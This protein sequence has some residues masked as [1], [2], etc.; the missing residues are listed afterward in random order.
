M[1]SH[2]LA[3]YV[4]KEIARCQ[5]QNKTCTLDELL[6]QLDVRR[7]DLRR[8]VSALHREGYVD[9]LRMRLTLQGFALGVGLSEV[10][11]PELRK[12][13]ARATAAA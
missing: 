10:Q 8:T 13:C 5:L 11:L 9:A 3:P 2:R 6:E 1:S 12:S 7:D 4:L